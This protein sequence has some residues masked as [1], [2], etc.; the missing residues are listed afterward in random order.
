MYLILPGGIGTLSELMD[1]VLINEVS[2]DKDKKDILIFNY[3]GIYDL[4]FKFLENMKSKQFIDLFCVFLFTT[5]K[6]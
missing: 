4:L 3:N 2:K 1:T 6:K 5:F